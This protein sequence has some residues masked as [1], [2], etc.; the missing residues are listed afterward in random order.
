[1]PVPTALAVK[2]D[3]VVGVA[4]APINTHW[5][6]GVSPKDTIVYWIPTDADNTGIIITC[7]TTGAGIGV[8]PDGVVQ[9]EDRVL[10]YF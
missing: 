6:V 2:I 1:M 9:G 10:T 8:E 3:P 4:A 7:G 5:V